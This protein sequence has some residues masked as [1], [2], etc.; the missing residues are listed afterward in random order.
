M[1]K[2]LLSASI[3]THKYLV[4]LFFKLT[5]KSLESQQVK[6]NGKIMALVLSETSSDTQLKQ[7]KEEEA[8]TN[9]LR[10]RK[11]AE[12]LSNR[13]DGVFHIHKH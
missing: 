5:D 2:F 13:S 12:A 4:L 3:I 9:V 10:T 8:V 11:A 7:N 6:N 1:K